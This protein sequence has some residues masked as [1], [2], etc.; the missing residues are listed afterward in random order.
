MQSRN[1]SLPL[2]LL[3]V[4]LLSCLSAMQAGAALTTLSL[5]ATRS[6]LLADGKQ[7]TDLIADVRDS[8]GRAVSNGVMVQ[9]QTTAGTLTEPSAQT[10]GG[11]ARVRLTSAP[12]AGVAHVTAF[13]AGASDTLEIVF[14]DDPA[15]TFEGNNYMLATATG[16]L[17]YSATDRVIEAQGKNGG[18]RV[19]FRNMDLTADSM[20]IRC[21]DSIVRAHDN[22]TL[23]RGGHTIHANRLYYS[24]QSGQGYALADLNGKLQTVTINGEALHL[25][26]SPTPIPS[27]YIIFPELQV[28]LV[29][30]ARSI[31]YF[32]NDRLQFRRPRFFQD[33]VQIMSL[34][35]YELP[36]NT[37]ELFSDQ[38]LS[39]G[40]NGF[41]LE[42]PFYYNLTPRSTGILYLRHQQQLGRGYYATEPG[43]ALDLIQ[44]YSNNGSDRRFEGAFGLTGLTRSDWGFRWQHNQEFNASTQGSFYLDFPHHDSLIS[45]GTFSQQ[46]H[47][48]R[49]GA[50][51]AAGQT[52]TGISD[53]NYRGDLYAETQ[54]HRLGSLKSLMYTIGTTLSSGSAISGDPKIGSV[55]ETTEGVTM[56]AFTRPLNLDARTTLTN[57]FSV[58]HLWSSSGSSGMTALATLAL[59][60]TIPHGGALNLTYDYVTQPGDLLVS[61]GKHRLSLTYNFAANKRFQAAIFG[62]AFLDARDSNLLADM[63]YRLNSHWRLLLSATLQQF[64]GL[65][66]NDIEFTL[67]RRIG[68]RELQLTYSTFRKRLSLDFTATRF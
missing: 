56:R 48:F 28:K 11:V 17:A 36:L 31:T 50:N 66:Y 22:I 10:F 65:S 19:T 41:G 45:S 47:T 2:F 42:L 7:S 29:I 26:P 20:Q 53:T 30:V 34:P 23:K 49:W 14:T 44:A 25:A 67:G 61:S 18:A 4:P 46:F 59:D 39:V 27:S 15:A 43:W 58:G 35:Y 68:A 3:I 9:F 33:Q 1:V 60:R 21:D 63:A 38:F 6:A 24:L 52:F 37:D 51:V 13:A 40:T 32:P 8:S 54:P 57:S 64:E 62:S 12:I 5:R 16:Y 55:H